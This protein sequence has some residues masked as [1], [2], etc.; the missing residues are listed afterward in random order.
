MLC[1]FMYVVASSDNWHV[2][3]CLSS[4]AAI[5]ITSSPTIMTSP[6][7]TTSRTT[8]TS[9]TPTTEPPG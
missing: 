4:T 3:Y 7:A 8:T 5:L 6:T 2:I 1:C 9:P